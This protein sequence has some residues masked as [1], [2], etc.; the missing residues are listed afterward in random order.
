MC[1]INRFFPSIDILWIISLVMYIPIQIKYRMIISIK[2]KKFKVCV[3]FV[4]FFFFRYT[5]GHSTVLNF[6]S[7]NY[8]GFSQNSGPCA[9]E[10]EQT[11]KNYG[12]SVC[13]SRQELGTRLQRPTLL[14]NS[15]KK[16]V[17]ITL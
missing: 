16:L 6:G 2:N 5:G 3:L 8:L 10:V 12:V 9:E 17:T 11:I 15:S 4:V 1:M 13:G 14:T 7:Y